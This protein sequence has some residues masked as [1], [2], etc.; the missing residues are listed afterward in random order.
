MVGISHSASFW[1][2][3]SNLTLDRRLA[4]TS[5]ALALPPTAGIGIAWIYGGGGVIYKED[6]LLVE[7]DRNANRER[8]PSLLLLHNALFPWLSFGANFKLLRYDLP[9]TQ[10]DQ[11]SGYRN[12]I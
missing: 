5:I 1:D 12:R 10:S 6:I 9:I 2:F 7:V 3:Y 4:A 11:V 8:M